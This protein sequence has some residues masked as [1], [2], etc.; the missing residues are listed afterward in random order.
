MVKSAF[1]NG[2]D[3]GTSRTLLGLLLGALA[4]SAAVLAA[5]TAGPAPASQE[6]VVDC[7]VGDP[8]A[9]AEAEPVPGPN[10]P[11]EY[12]SWLATDDAQAGVR[13]VNAE[14]EQR[15]GVDPSSWLDQGYFGTI[16]D[17]YNQELRVVVDSGLVD[18]GA[19]QADLD[20][21]ASSQVE[22]GALAVRVA[23]ACNSASEIAESEETVSSLDWVDESEPQRVS[24]SID[25]T[26]ST[27]AVVVTPRS[28]D[29]AD[30]LEAQEGDTVTISEGSLGRA[31]RNTDTEPHKG[32][33][34]I[35]RA[36]DT[37]NICTSA[38]TAILPSGEKGSVSAGHCFSNGQTIRSGS[39]A[40]GEA[41]GESNFPTFDMI[42]IKPQG[43]SFTRAVYGT[44]GSPS[45][46]DVTGAENPSA[47]ELLCVS[48]MVSEQICDV[49]VINLNAEFCDASGCT[50]NLAKARKNGT[51]VTRPGDSGGPVYRRDGNDAKIRGMIIAFDAPESSLFHKVNT[52]KDHL[53]ITSIGG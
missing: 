1:G 6:E 33:A 39:T 42:R 51:N 53:G 18:I 5:L 28:D 38:F 21:A 15:F 16:A 27:V 26:S 24:F 41:A 10:Q 37:S 23:N 44:P 11:Y 7:E 2:V 29:S 49:E 12:Q 43:E 8:A 34:G 52:I 4:I 50:P 35:R 9:L 19:L 32:G 22:P 17:H 25:P 30:E 36:A 20:A 48:G 31:G 45:V 3:G 46:R 47:G 14:L 13:A 40:Y